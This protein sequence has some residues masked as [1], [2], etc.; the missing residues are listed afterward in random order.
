VDGQPSAA[1]AEKKNRK[2]A[3]DKQRDE[4]LKAAKGLGKR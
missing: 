2:K 1:R 3:G 4:L